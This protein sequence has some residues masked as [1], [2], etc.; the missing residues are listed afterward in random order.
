[1]CA[2]FQIAQ[3][4]PFEREYQVVSSLEHDGHPNPGNQRTEHPK[5]DKS[6]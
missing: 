2:V 1:M 4:N 6:G 5:R 3:R